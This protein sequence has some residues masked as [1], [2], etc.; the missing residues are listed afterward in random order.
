MLNCVSLDFSL[1][2]SYS[3]YETFFVSAAA[4]AAQPKTWLD[5]DTWDNLK[6]L[7][8]SSVNTLDDLL[9]QGECALRNNS[10]SKGSKSREHWHS[11]HAGL[12]V[13]YELT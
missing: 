1:A 8:E 4:A 7:Q 9:V 2:R 10:C 6:R 3:S 5:S 12:F 11:T 13:S